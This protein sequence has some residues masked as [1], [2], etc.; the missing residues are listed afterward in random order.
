M[1]F[2]L[3]DYPFAGAVIAGREG[4]L[5]QLI[6]VHSNCRK[7]AQTRGKMIHNACTCQVGFRR[8]EDLC[9]GKDNTSKHL[10]GPDS[11]TT[12]GYVSELCSS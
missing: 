2:G 10:C 6:K 1:L 7:L 4:Y 3:C 9:T 11:A 5:S 8:V 12:G